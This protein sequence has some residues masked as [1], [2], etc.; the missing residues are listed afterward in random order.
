MLWTRSSTYAAR[1]VFVTSWTVPLCSFRDHSVP[2][3]VRRANRG[4]WRSLPQNDELIAQRVRG[5]RYLSDKRGGTSH[6]G[7]EWSL[8]GPF[9]SSA[10]PVLLERLELLGVSPSCFKR[11]VCSRNP[12]IQAGAYLRIGRWKRPAHYQAVRGRSRCIQGG[13]RMRATAPLEHL[14]I[15]TTQYCKRGLNEGGASSTAACRL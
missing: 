14:A 12:A 2:I 11:R 7:R 5:I 15:C 13:A 1:P 8:R 10:R 9:A 6:R 3:F 4:Q